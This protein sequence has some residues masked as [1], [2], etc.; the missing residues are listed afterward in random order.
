MFNLLPNKDSEWDVKDN[1]DLIKIW[2][3]AEIGLLPSGIKVALRFDSLKAPISI[4]LLLELMM[5]MP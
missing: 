4:D 3:S 2:K 5:L 1:G